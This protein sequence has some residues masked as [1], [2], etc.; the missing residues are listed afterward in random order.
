MLRR[1]KEHKAL[2]Y[3]LIQ[4]MFKNA[5]YYVTDEKKWTKEANLLAQSHYVMN[6]GL[7]P[8]FAFKFLHTLSLAA[9]FF[10]KSLCQGAQTFGLPR[11]VSCR[12]HL[13]LYFWRWIPAKLQLPG[14]PYPWYQRVLTLPLDVSVIQ[15]L[16]FYPAGPQ[17]SERALHQWFFLTLAALGKLF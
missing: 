9:Q 3:C 1:E 12:K 13:T 8:V 16:T 14:T 2:T 11:Y 5:C 4:Y 17:G 6:S 15:G 10:C 7:T